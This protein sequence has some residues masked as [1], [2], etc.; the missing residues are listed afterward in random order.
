MPESSSHTVLCPC[1]VSATTPS[2]VPSPCL[3]PYPAA[4]RAPAPATDQPCAAGATGIDGLL[5]M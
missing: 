4:G 1:Q 2:P 5:V 3:P